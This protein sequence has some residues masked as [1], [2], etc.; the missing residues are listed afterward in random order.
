[1]SDNLDNVR[2]IAFGVI[3]S[4]ILWIYLIDI[5]LTMWGGG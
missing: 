5:A 1:M 4:L 2:G 3:I